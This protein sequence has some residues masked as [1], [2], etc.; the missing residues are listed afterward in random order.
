MRRV[1]C[2]RLG[3]LGAL[4]V[5]GGPVA[6][7]APPAVVDLAVDGCPDVDEARLRELLAIELRAVRPDGAGDVDVRLACAGTRATLDLHDRAFGRSWRAEV[8]LA[9]TPEATR[10]RLLVLAAT[11]RLIPAA[12]PSA[13]PAR[14]SVAPGPRSE[15][16][17]P[18][19][20]APAVVAATAAPV[21]QPPPWRAGARAS[22]R[23]AGAPATW[24][25]GAGAGVERALGRGLALGLDLVAEAGDATTA[26]ARVA[27]RDVV[28]T[29]G[30]VAEAGVGRWSV[31]A[32]P[33][34]SVGLASLAATPT[35]PDARGGTLD[36]VWTGPVVEARVRRAL[37]RTAY[38][39]AEAGG[40][41][42][43]RR[44]SGLV[45]GEAELFQLRGPWLALGL[46][47]GLT[48]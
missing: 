9:G 41:Y 7:A 3:A 8:D 15:A 45:D 26:L 37:G 19:A 32:R 10:L 24:L 12:P 44:V 39:A 30:V 29:V 27:V 18:D 46:G 6:R 25:A 40:G 2:A 33:G 1:R 17:A 5:A 16:P 4:L 38:V 20:T 23:R 42:T 43:L 28:A 21:E 34:F 11:E 36:A 14:A 35:A 13:E 47:A 48:F 31:G 22:L